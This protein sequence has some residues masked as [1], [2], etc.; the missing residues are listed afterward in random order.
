M[1]R[2]HSNDRAESRSSGHV[3]QIVRPAEDPTGSN[4]HCRSENGPSRSRELCGQHGCDRDRCRRMPGRERV[5]SAASGWGELEGAGMHKLGARA[6]NGMFQNVGA[7]RSKTVRDETLPASVFPLRM[8][9]SIPDRQQHEAQDHQSPP[10]TEPITDIAELSQPGIGEVVHVEIVEGTDEPGQ[11]HI[12]FKQ[13]RERKGERT[14]GEEDGCKRRESRIANYELRE[15]HENRFTRST[16]NNVSRRLK[17]ARPLT[18]PTLAA[19]SPARPESAKTDS[20]PRDAPYPKQG[21]SKRTGEA[22]ASV[23]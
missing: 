6:A 2:N 20:S 9:Q 23:R 12:P 11:R 4:G 3:G 10:F 17:K 5:P 19:T 1:D 8:F 18:R 16:I 7:Q 14:D 15:S 21:R 22:Y 13:P